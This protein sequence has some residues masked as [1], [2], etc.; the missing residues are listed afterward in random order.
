MTTVAGRNA[1]ASPRRANL[2]AVGCDEQVF[3]KGLIGPFTKTRRELG[4]LSG[5]QRAADIRRQN[6]AQ[7]CAS[8]NDIL[9]D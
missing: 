5:I 4:H 9:A 2:Q 1:L 8:K 3:I 6:I 7:N